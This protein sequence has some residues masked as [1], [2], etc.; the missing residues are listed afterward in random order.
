MQGDTYWQ[1][2][3]MPRTRAVNCWN[4]SLTACLADRA[5]DWR[6]L[7]ASRMTATCFSLSSSSS[8]P[9]TSIF[10]LSALDAVEN[11]SSSRHWNN[12]AG[13]CASG[14]LLPFWN[15]RHRAQKSAHFAG[16][17]E[18]LIFGRSRRGCEAFFVAAA[19]RCGR[20]WAAT[21]CATI[22]APGSGWVTAA[23]TN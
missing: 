22:F 18:I 3:T 1:S 9:S 17:Q 4:L 6:I 10:A 8:T 15:R 12:F 7:M 13:A 23:V 2:I 16:L 21:T 11:S 14:M 20:S 19:G 5:S